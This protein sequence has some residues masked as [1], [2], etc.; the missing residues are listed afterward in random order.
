MKIK[1]L[2]LTLSLLA[3]GARAQVIVGNYSVTYVASAPSGSCSQNAPLQFLTPSGILYACQNGTWTNIT[4][5]G[6]GSGT[7]SG[8]ATGIIPLGTTP[9]AISNQ[10]HMDD[11]IS[12]ASTITS[13]EAFVA[14]SLKACISGPCLTFTATAPAESVNLDWSLGY[15][16]LL[17]SLHGQFTVSGVDC[18]TDS[19]PCNYSSSVTPDPGYTIGTPIKSGNSYGVEFPTPSSASSL[20][21]AYGNGLVSLVFTNG[22]TA[23][24]QLGEGF[25]NL[26]SNTA[27]GTS[28]TDPQAVNSASG[29]GAILTLTAVS[30]GSGFSGSGTIVLTNFNNSCSGSQVTVTLTAGAFSSAVVNT[31]GTSCTAAATTATCTSGTATCTGSPVTI[32][33]TTTVSA[34]T[35]G[36]SGGMNTWTAGLPIFKTWF[37]Y[38]AAGDFSAVRTYIGFCRGCTAAILN[39]DT[40]NPG[41]MAMVRYSTVAGDATWMCYTSDGT[42]ASALAIP[43]ATPSTTGVAI[44]VDVNSGSTVCKVGANSVTKNTNPPTTSATTWIVWDISTAQAGAS[45]NTRINGEYIYYQNRSY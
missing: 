36:E 7:V 34:L 12:A 17:K 10:S 20:L 1:F 21:A 40:P 24:T 26:G 39:S 44:E 41:V 37:R 30:G 35:S 13:S 3:A 4:G 8:Q 15:I 29:V 11:G 9:T 43:G 27:S 38:P 25:T 32:N 28:A 19:S 22:S 31:A 16:G 45:I 33:V 14:P 5:G 42:T 2:L 6:G 18:A 23:F